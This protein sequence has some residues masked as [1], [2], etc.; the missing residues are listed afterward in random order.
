MNPISDTAYYC[1]GLRMQDAESD[2]PIC[3]DNYAKYFINDHGMEVLDR[4]QGIETHRIGNLARHKIID[5]LINDELSRHPD[6]TAI[7]IGAGFDTRSFRL[8]G[9][10]WVEIDEPAIIDYKNS[11]LP[12]ADCKN[13]LVR[14]PHRFSGDSLEQSLGPYKHGRHIVII[15]EGVFRYLDKKDINDLFPALQ[16]IFSKYKLICDLM[17]HAFNEIYADATRDIIKQM[18]APVKFSMDR[19]ELFFQDMNHRLV[20]KISVVKYAVDNNLLPGSIDTKVKDPD[21][22]FDGYSICRF[23][24][25]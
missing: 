7:L 21:V 15:I 5:D 1:A 20:D 16:G 19:P 23:E 18:G 3:G 24:Y 17:S 22:L 8:D 25:S 9:G 13:P 10:T 4:F 12:A 11:C 6:L 14:I 2:S